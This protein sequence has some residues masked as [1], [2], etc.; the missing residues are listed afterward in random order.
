[1]F[2][3]EIPEEFVE[4]IADMMEKGP[5]DR[6]QTAAE[7]VARLEPWAAEAS[8]I[9]GQKLGS[10]SP[11]TAPPPPEDDDQAQDTD[12]GQDNSAGSSQFSQATAVTS[13]ASQETIPG[14]PR[15]NTPAEPMV[16]NV[17]EESSDAMT[18]IVLTLAV[19]VPLSM[20]AG[21]VLASLVFYLFK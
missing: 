13:S 20:L 18:Y 15:R 17:G 21:A 9:S 10:K 8:P 3:P 2:N 7:V 16:V 1:R 14:K 19:S 6:I 5:R 4:V 11:W 12:G